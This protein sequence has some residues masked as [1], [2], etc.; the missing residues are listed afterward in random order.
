M[1]ADRRRAR[2]Y[3]FAA[4]IELTDLQSLTQ[5]K[6]QTKDLSLFGCYVNTRRFLP[7]G[8][9]V[10]LRIARQGA[11]F[12]GFGRV[13]NLQS[14]RGIGIFF[15]HVESKHGLVLEKWLAELRGKQQAS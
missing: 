11:V 2:R 15:T 4:S 8:A 1:Q 13:V 5:T 7:M 9:K 12:E 6:E 3:P 10:R 14:E